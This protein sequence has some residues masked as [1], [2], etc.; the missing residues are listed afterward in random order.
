[1]G[2]NQLTPLVV[3]LAA[4]LLVALGIIASAPMLIAVGALCAVVGAV[5]ARKAQA[6]NGPEYKRVVVDRDRSRIPPTPLSIDKQ[7][8]SVPDKAG[9]ALRARTPTAPPVDNGPRN[10][11]PTTPPVDHGQMPPR[12][13]TSSS[14]PID[15]ASRLGSVGVEVTVRPPLPQPE[16]LP[17][18][19]IPVAPESG[20][21]IRK[22]SP[23][24]APQPLPVAPSA[25]RLRGRVSYAV[26][27][28]ALSSQGI[29]GTRDDGLV[30]LVAWKDVVGIVARRMPELTPYDGATFIDVV[31][32]AGATLR[33][34]PWTDITGHAMTA[35]P[36]ERARSLAQLI[37]AQ[38][39]DAQLDSATT[40]F[41]NGSGPAAQL[42]D[43][44]TLAAHDAKL[45]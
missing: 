13:R 31:S 42:R 11:T 45:A 1:M 35:D 21:V 4:I 18:D 7:P 40:S 29:T 8:T 33:I 15:V 16:P 12:A 25:P 19:Q 10:R 28:A 26:S 23:S 17:E 38:C 32:T 34:L 39:L 30:R 43:E 9:S 20:L 2:R 41:V 24:T 5:F 37:A 22:R 27:T 14:G 6:E 44:K 3:S 36:V